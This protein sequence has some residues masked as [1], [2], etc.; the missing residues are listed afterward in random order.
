MDNPWLIDSVKGVRANADESRTNSY[1]LKNEKEIR[2]ILFI[3]CILFYTWN[4]TE[5]INVYLKR[6]SEMGLFQESI[7]NFHVREI[8]LSIL[9][10][11]RPCM[12]TYIYVFNTFARFNK[13]LSRIIQSN[14]FHI[15]MCCEAEYFSGK[16]LLREIWKTDPL[17]HL[18]STD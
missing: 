7:I 13:S 18:K 4:T 6:W 1:F 3:L 17:F 14:L 5:G 16:R 15:F 9:C 2:R 11:Q 10:P 8:K 12:P